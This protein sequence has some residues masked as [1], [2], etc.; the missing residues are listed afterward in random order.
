MRPRSRLL[1]RLSPNLLFVVMAG[2]LFGV[3][4]ISTGAFY[5]I[6]FR[7]QKETAHRHVRHLCEAAAL[8]V[9]VDKHEQLFGPAQMGSPLHLE[10][11]APL[12]RFHLAIPALHYV[13]TMRIDDEFRESFVLDTA[14]DPRVRNLRSDVILSPIGEIFESSLPTAEANAAMIRGETYV[15]DA[16]YV[17][18]F[19]EYLSAQTPLF[20]EDGRLVGYLGVDYR[21]EAYHAQLAEVRHA[22]IVALLVGLIVSLLVAEVLRRAQRRNLAH[23]DVLSQTNEALAEARD[24][25]EQTRAENTEFLRL[26]AH[27]LKNPLHA[28]KTMSQLMLSDGARPGARREWTEKEEEYI[29]LIEQS[30]NH[31]ANLVNDLLSRDSLGVQSDSVSDQLVDLSTLALDLIR[32]NQASLERKSLRLQTTI[33]PGLHTRGDALRLREALDNLISNAVKFSPPK[34]GI[35]LDLAPDPQRPEFLVFTVRDEGPGVAP[36]EISRLFQ[37]FQRLSAQP[38]GGEGS[39]GLGLSLVKTIAEHHGGAVHYEPGEERG[40]VFRLFLPRA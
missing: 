32:F 40:A 28:I 9:D 22:A 8:L 20:T 13:Y 39:T 7:H 30:A 33:A 14:Y 6:T 3:S 31:M 2:L 5:W 36:Q 17:D 12:V 35:R 29:G 18:S 4:A 16:P 25:S 37:P 24:A 10:L 19:G 34:T 11:L 15:F 26:A 38:T 1:F 27:E 23:I 21:L